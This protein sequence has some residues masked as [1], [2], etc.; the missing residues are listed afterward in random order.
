MALQ[1]R[2]IVLEKR[3]M[4]QLHQSGEQIVCEGIGVAPYLA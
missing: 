4:G 2:E 3:Q 1:N